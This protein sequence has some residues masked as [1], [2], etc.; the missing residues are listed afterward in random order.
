MTKYLAVD[1]DGTEI[2]FVLGNLQRDRVTV[3][4]AGSEPIETSEDASGQTLKHYGRTLKRLLGHHNIS[5]NRLLLG[6]DRSSVEL[7]SLQIPPATKEEILDLVTHQALHDSPNF[8]E[9]QPLDFLLLSAA[10]GETQRVAALTITR[11]QLKQYRGICHEARQK[12]S[13]IV[14]RPFTIADLYCQS[15]L[16]DDK[17]I[18]LFQA[19]KEEADVVVLVEK[20][21]V[22][23]RSFKFPTVI[24]QE[25]RSKRIVTEIN[26][27]LTVAQQEL[28]GEELRKVLIFGDPEA[29]ASTVAGFA[30]REIDIEVRNP[31]Q[32]N[33]VGGKVKPDFPGSYAALLGMILAES[34]G[35][36]QSIDFLHP[37]EKPQPI[38]IAR[39]AVLIF[40]LLSIIG[41]FFYFHAKKDL[42]TLDAQLAGLEAK[43]QEQQKQY[44]AD[45][46]LFMRLTAAY[47]W[48][49]AQ[50]IWLDELRDLCV[51]LPAEQDLVITNMSFN[52]TAAGNYTG[53]IDLSGRARDWGTVQNI[54]R[55]FTD[56]FHSIRLVNQSR[57]PAGGGYPWNFSLRIF[58]VRRTHPDL[59]LA[60]LPEDIREQSGKLPDFINS[61]R[62]SQI[63]QNASNTQN[64]IISS[65]PQEISP[66][67]YVPREKPVP[68]EVPP[69][70]YKPMEKPIPQ[71]V[72]P[73]EY[74][75]APPDSPAETTPLPYIPLNQTGQN[76]ENPST[77]SATESSE[78]QESPSNPT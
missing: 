25:E 67:P 15:N 2:R 48:D 59:F 45:S 78:I 39:Y 64:I 42:K 41:V 14:F 40:L 36:G 17:P 22:F 61:N 4:K 54:H 58:C 62:T 1:W 21:I 35:S 20:R 38:N 72:R 71:E 53:V 7:M 37:K 51:R 23:T 43:I 60:H 33:C 12:P 26:R 24:S 63:P 46:P 65:P 69:P 16:A 52:G 11:S 28:S 3:L 74:S 76:P 56:N 57:N 73:P 9:G 34:T 30:D 70:E 5:R 29:S 47:T 19:T 8:T 32:L 10:S 75:S 50:L 6:L 27:T 31:F 18:L 66:E 13:K 77:P 55:S 68:E 44:Q 49:N